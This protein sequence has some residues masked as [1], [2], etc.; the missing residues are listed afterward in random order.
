MCYL[1]ATPLVIPIDENLTQM[2]LLDKSFLFIDKTG[3]LAFKDIEKQKFEAIDKKHLYFGYIYNAKFWIKFTLKNNSNQRLKRI[4]SFQTAEVI[5]VYGGKQIFIQKGHSETIKPK[6][7]LSFEPNE[8]KTYYI[9]AYSKVKVVRAQL[10]IYN[11]WAFL[12]N[13]SRYIIT[14]VIFFTALGIMFIYN[15]LLLFVTKDSLYGYYLLYLSALCLF[16][17]ALFD[18][19]KLYISSD[20]FLMFLTKGVLLPLLFLVFAITLFSIKFLN[21]FK[22]P[23]LYK[24]LRFYLYFAAIVALISYNN[25]II[26]TF[27]ALLILS[28]WLV[29]VVS[30]GFWAWYKGEGQ[31]KYYIFGWSFFSVV[32]ILTLLRTIGILSISNELTLIYVYIASFIIETLFFSLSITHKIEILKQNEEAKLK[33]L[34]AQKTEKIESMLE[35]KELLY[36]E[37]NHRVKNNIQ[38]ILSLLTL[39]IGDTQS[40]ETKEEL[41]STK[42]RVNSLL[43]LYDK[44]YLDSNDIYVDTKTYLE[45]IVQTVQQTFKN[46]VEINLNIQYRLDNSELIYCGLIVNELVTNSFKYAFLDKGYINISLSKNANQIY[47]NINDNGCGFEKSNKKS[48]GMEIVKALVIKQ[49]LGTMEITSSTK[50]T[51]ISIVWEE[52]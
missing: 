21:I 52:R 11:E 7:E 46:S 17:L 22:F 32:A 5:K 12:K 34:V 50:G 2:E 13:E 30:S 47:L 36:Q 1:H 40:K 23:I 19:F 28:P 9:E 39:Q 20:V 6:F 38:M 35:Q 45:N 42:N 51:N 37:L 41:T 8:V 44:L 26:N 29:I 15:L 48:L 4:L 3:K 24:I 43:G 25:W 33:L 31:A 18:I 49:F 14:F 16:Q 10:T 27:T